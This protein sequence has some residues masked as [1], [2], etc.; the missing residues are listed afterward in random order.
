M[1]CGGWGVGRG[2]HQGRC[3]TQQ[4][5]QADKTVIR[6]MLDVAVVLGPKDSRGGQDRSWGGAKKDKSVSRLRGCTTKTC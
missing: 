3:S 6:H 2:I 1:Y 4:R 5:G